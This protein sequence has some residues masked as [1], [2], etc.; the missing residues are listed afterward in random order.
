MKQDG[1]NPNKLPLDINKQMLEIK[2]KI[3]LS[4]K[5]SEMFLCSLLITKV[6]RG[7]SKSRLRRMRS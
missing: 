5:S 1:N 4:G 3:Q 6:N 2:K 7:P